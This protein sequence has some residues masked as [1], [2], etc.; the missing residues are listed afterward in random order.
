MVEERIASEYSKG[1]IRCPTHLS[2]GQEAVA[3]GV[4]AGLTLEDKVVSTHRAH[5]H[6]LAK[7]GDLRGLI[8]ELYG[9]EQGCSAGRGGSMHLVDLKAGFYG[10]TA[11]VGNTIPIGV[12]LAYA[13]KISY[14]SNTVVIYIGDAAIEEG[15]FYESLNFAAL[16]RLPVL[17]VCE[18]N[19]YSVYTPLKERQPENRRLEDVAAG[20]GARCLSGDGND[21]EQ[22]RN[23]SAFAVSECRVGRGPFF[24]K[25][26]TYRW[27]EHCGP[28]YDNH[29]GYRTEGEFLEWKEKDPIERFLL[30]MKESEKI[31][32]QVIENF[33]REIQAEIDAEIAFA[34]AQ[35][36]PDPKT[37]SLN[38]FKVSP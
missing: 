4:S 31:S 8:C 24:L 25:L 32:G 15:V 28:N 2:I 17:F 5:A 12:G 33:R 10:S 1:L 19:M 22:V 36:Y 37:A 3:A 30:K 9:K 29:I 27:R 14:S 34:E 26:D 38:V 18:N 35:P 23:L 20:I 6:Y 16:H 21:V 11:I 13:E 7:G